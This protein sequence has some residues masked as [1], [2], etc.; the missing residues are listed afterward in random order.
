MSF[1]WTDGFLGYYQLQYDSQC[2]VSNSS[3]GHHNWDVEEPNNA[4]GSLECVQINEQGMW[5]D[6]DC[7]LFKNYT[8]VQR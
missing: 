2:L 6:Q 1:A 3:D 4:T 7:S 8:C 5:S